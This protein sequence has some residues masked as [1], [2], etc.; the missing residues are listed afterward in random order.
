ML[1]VGLDYVLVPD[2]SARS[3]QLL[4][5]HAVLLNFEILIIWASLREHV[6]KVQ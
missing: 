6:D 2:R 4:V 1:R 3:G 5:R